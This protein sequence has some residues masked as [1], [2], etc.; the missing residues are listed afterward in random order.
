MH[1]NTVGA[2]LIDRN[3]KSRSDSMATRRR[4]PHRKPKKTPF[5]SRSHPEAEGK[6]VLPGSGRLEDTPE[7]SAAGLR[8]LKETTNLPVAV[9]I[10]VLAREY[11]QDS[12]AAET[13]CRAAAG[14]AEE[15]GLL[16][17]YRA[18][19]DA[20]ETDLS[21]DQAFLLFDRRQS[22]DLINFYKSKD[23]QSALNKE[24]AKLRQIEGRLLL[25]VARPSGTGITDE[26]L[27]KL[28][29]FIKYSGF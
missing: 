12:Q 4:S 3:L 11:T 26:D 27:E 19:W 22:L 25:D 15:S 28:E 24:L 5:S 16:K 20:E 29:E 8:P 18:I 7:K 9:V 1:N 21:A 17:H 10:E 14:I 23:N 2:I 6:P 13:L